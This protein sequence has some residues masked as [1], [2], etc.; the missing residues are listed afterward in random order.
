[1][2]QCKRETVTVDTYKLDLSHEEACVLWRVL[3]TVGGSPSG[4][5]GLVSS[6]EDAL[7]AKIDLAPDTLDKMFFCTGGISLRLEAKETPCVP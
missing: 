6:I 4:P 7:R 2:A 1:M 5:R 3:R